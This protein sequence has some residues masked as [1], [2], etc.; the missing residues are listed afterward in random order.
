MG[1]ITVR[2]LDVDAKRRLRARA[3]EHGRSIEK[4]A[5]EILG[6]VVGHQPQRKT[7][8]SRSMIVLLRLVASTCSRQDPLQGVRP[9]CSST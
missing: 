1:S 7:L 5:R 2:N 4:E 9:S 6:Q 8:A 3:A